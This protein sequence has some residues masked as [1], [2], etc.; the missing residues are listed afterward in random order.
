[1]TTEQLERIMK[2]RR[3]LKEKKLTTR[4]HALKNWLEANFVS[5]KYWTIEEV[6]EG[7]RDT[8]G[9]PFYILN[10]NPHKH[11][12]CLALANDVKQLNWHTGR[13]RYIPII[14]DTKGSIK[15]AENREELQNYVDEEEAR[16][17]NTY[18]YYNHLKSLVG[19]D[20]EVHF[21]NQANR[22]LEEDEIKPIEVYVR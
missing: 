9:E 18:M 17:E 16:I 20:G 22:V 4:Q 19:L 2:K 3:E 6:V 10:K 11:D 12:K 1:M 13:E 15:L 21:I 14:K 5:G 8:N 7:V